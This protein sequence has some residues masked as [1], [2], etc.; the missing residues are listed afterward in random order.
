MIDYSA[1]DN[2]VLL[3]YLFFPRQ[4][5]T[6]CL[7]NSFDLG[8]IVAE[9]TSIYCRFYGTNSDLPWMLFFHG[10]GEVV[11]DFDNIAPYFKQIGI[12]IVVADYRGYGNSEGKPSFTNLINDAHIIY[13]TIREEIKKRGY[14]NKLWLMGRS[15]G[16]ISALELALNYQDEIQGMV[17]ESGFYSISELIKHLGL[18]HAGIDLR[19]IE[20]RCKETVGTIKIPTLIIHG[21]NDVLVPAK[22]GRYLFEKIA[23]KE[24]HLLL[25][26]SAGHNDLL[27]Y[28]LQDYFM[29]IREFIIEKN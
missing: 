15:L 21:E 7:E 27:Y 23:S 17:I 29:A 1:I 3:D 26:P 16:S 11:S 14:N 28:G 13:K 22:Q 4:D 24:K 8:V 20:E 5:F 6:P 25:I 2:S 10:N 18:P 19:N 12:N 9:N